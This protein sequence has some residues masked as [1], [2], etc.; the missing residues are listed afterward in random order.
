MPASKPDAAALLDAAIDYL[1]GELA[2]TLAGYHRFQLRVTVNVLAQVR[3]ELALAAAQADAERSRLIALVG[4]PGDRDE[5]SR[6]LAAQIRA[7]DSPARRS[8]AARP[9]AQLA[10]R[11][12][13]DQQPSLDRRG[14]ARR[15]LSSPPA[16]ACKPIARCSSTGAVPTTQRPRQR[17]DQLNV[18][19]HCPVALLCL[20][21]AT[22]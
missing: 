8:S 3:R 12:A 17:R 7:G 21:A 22:H 2:P 20:A 13:T 16:S 5:L 10:R 9:P 11:G 19:Y 14:P 18:V 4:H 1:T 6:E 15:Q